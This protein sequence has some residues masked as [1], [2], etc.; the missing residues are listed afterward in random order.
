MTKWKKGQGSLDQ[1]CKA[2]QNDQ[3][4]VHSKQNWIPLAHLCSRLDYC[5]S[6]LVG[7][8]L[9]LIKRLQGVQNTAARS[10]LKTPRSEHI[11]PLLQNL[12]W[13]PVNRRILHKVTA[14]CHTSLSGFGPQYLSDLTHVYTPARSLHSSSDTRI[15]STPNVKLK[16]YGQHSFAY[17][18]PTTWNSLPL[19]LGHQQESEC[20]KLA[21]KTHLFSLN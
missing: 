4:S 3:M 9:Y 5:N 20:F 19:A 16:S 7:L 21:L 1:D 18:G 17:H 2:V 13:L 8:P 10:I 15:L 12:H 11:S 6:L 14:L